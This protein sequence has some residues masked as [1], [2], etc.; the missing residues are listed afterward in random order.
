MARKKRES[1]PSFEIEEN[2]NDN[3]GDGD[4]D[5]GNT[6]D[7]GGGR[8]GDSGDGDGAGIGA[9]GRVGADGGASHEFGELLYSASVG[10]DDDE[11]RSEQPARRATGRGNQRGRRRARPATGNERNETQERTAPAADSTPR[12]VR[13]GSLGAPSG[14][15]K[16][17]ASAK[18]SALTSAFLAEV[19]GLIFHFIGTFVE[20]DEWRL[21]EDDAQELG[22]RTQRCLAMLGAKNLASVQMLLGKVQPPAALLMS[23]AAVVS[24]RVKHTREKKRNAV[25][26][27]EKAKAGRGTQT[28]PPV[29]ENPSRMATP[30]AGATNGH[31]G[32]PERW[33]GVSFGRHAWEQTADGNVS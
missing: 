20:D 27:P 25:N 26:P 29:S 11:S 28:P 6:G 17:K 1:K 14:N 24:V 16:S 4:G 10:D 12:Q 32:G 2:G 7:S 21:P 8:S 19:Y 18:D 23:L 13:F 15:S 22:E 9:S 30:G 33:D 3:N 5:D 31:A